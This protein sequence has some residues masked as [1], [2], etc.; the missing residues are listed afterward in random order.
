[1]RAFQIVDH[2]HVAEPRREASALAKSLGFQDEDIGRIALITTELATNLS[3]HG[4]GGEILIGASLDSK[5]PCVEI[6]AVDKGP[7]MDVDACLADGFSTAG[8]QGT[9]LGACRRQATT[10]DAYSA[11]GFGTAIH[12]RVCAGRK[13]YKSKQHISWGAVVRPL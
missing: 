12:I 8:S 2:S 9:G 11:D 6:L 13:P 5:E 4:G 7:G 3:K 1:M 10:F